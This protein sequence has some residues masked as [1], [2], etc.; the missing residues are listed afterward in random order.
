MILERLSKDHKRKKYSMNWLC[1]CIE[2]WI[3]THQYNV[4]MKLYANKMWHLNK[5]CKSLENK[6]THKAE[7]AKFHNIN[8]E[9]LR[10]LSKS[11]LL[12]KFQTWIP[13]RYY[14]ILNFS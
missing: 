1:V 4:F 14:K 10:M 12:K 5:V 11:S 7:M 2:Y 3:D 9:E 8:G 6:H 13:F